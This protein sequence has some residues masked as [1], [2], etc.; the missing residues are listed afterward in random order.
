M[1]KTIDYPF[2]YRKSSDGNNL[3]GIAYTTDFKQ[4]WQNRILLVLGTK[5]GERVMRPDFG[6][7]LYSVLF[8]SQENA[9]Q[10]AN[11]S[12]NEAFVTWL[13]DLLLKQIN[14]SFDQTTNTLIINILYALPN[15]EVDSVT[16]NTGIFN[17][18]GDLIQEITNG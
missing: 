14:P 2:T 5:P 8:E 10:I 12:I 3:S 7:N 6:S 13:P 9:L 1:I 11:T 15:G 17:R 16:I 4:I 18:S